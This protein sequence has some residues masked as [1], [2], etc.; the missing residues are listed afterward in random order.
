MK[1]LFIL[2]FVLIVVVAVFTARPGDARLHPPKP[3]EAGVT[4]FLIDNGFHSDIALP[5]DRLARTGGVTATAART[6]T[7]RAWVF[8]GWGDARFYVEEGLSPRRVLDG[9]RA[10]FAPRNPSVVRLIGIRAAPDRLYADEVVTEI[11]VSEAGFRALVARIDRSMAD[12][13]VIPVPAD[14]PVARDRLFFKSV[15]TFNL[16]H[17]C[18]HWTGEVLNAAGLGVTPVLATFPIG[19]KIDLQMRARLRRTPLDTAPAGA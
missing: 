4:V 3:G 11:L 13:G 14:A 19:L 5:A 10:L 17:L 2:L 12:D 16:I 18:N 1:R 8:V 15:E 7:P 9:L 6:L